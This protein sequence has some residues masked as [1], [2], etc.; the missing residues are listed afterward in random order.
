[1]DR[2]LTEGAQAIGRAEEEVSCRQG[3]NDVTLAVNLPGAVQ[4]TPENPALQIATMT[5]EG[6]DGT[7]TVQTY[8]GMRK[9]GRG[10]YA[11]SSHEFILLNGKPVYLRGA[12]H[13]SFNPEGVYTHPDD[14]FIRRDYEKAKE[15]GLNFLRIHIK[16]DEP[17]ALYWADRLG[18]MLMCDMPNF[19]RK[20]DRSKRLWQQ[21]MY[22]AVARDFNH[23]AI[24]AW[25]NFNET[26]GIGDNGYD[27]ETQNWVRDMYLET[28]R[29]DPT[30][31]VE[32]NS[33]C[34]YDHTVSDINSWHFYID[35]Y[36]VARRHIEEVTQKHYPGSAFNYAQG[37]KQNTAPLI[38]S[39]Y[40]GVGAGSGDRDISW[41]F[42]HLT[43][44]LRS[45]ETIGGYVYT[46]LSDIEWEHNGFMNYDRSDKVYGYPA[47]I[48]LKDLQGEE[49]VV[50]RCAPYRRVEAGGRA[51]V[52]ISL[53]HW[54]EREGLRLRLSAHGETIAGE[55]WDRYVAPQM[56]D[57]RAVPYHVTPQGEFTVELPQESGIL[58]LA[59]EA[60]DGDKRVA[61]NYCV[62]DVRGVPLDHAVDQYAIS[63]P[64]SAFSDCSFANQGA[65]LHEQRDKVYGF[66]SGQIAY[67]LKLPDDLRGDNIEGC[68]LILELGA[69]ADDELLDWPARRN[70]M[71]YPQTD[72]RTHPTA[73]QIAVNGNAAAKI[74]IGSDYADARGVLSHAAGFHHGSHGAVF[75][76]DLAEANA[77]AGLQALLA[78]LAADR[79]VILTLTALEDAAGGLALYGKEMGQFPLDPTLLFKLKP[80]APKPKGKAGA[81]D[82]TLSSE[83]EL[84]KT[85]P[86]GDLWRFTFE[87]PAEEWARPGFDDAAWRKGK[88]GFGTPETPGARIGTRWDTPD[89]WLRTNVDLPSE[90]GAEPVRLV[91]HHD[92]DVKVY[93]NGDLLVEQ[94][95][96]LQDYEYHTLTPD[97]IALF[98]PGGQNL[99]AVHCRQTT[100][101]QFIDVGLITIE[102]KKSRS[103]E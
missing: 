34:S 53:S 22:E 20:T 81:V 50:L 15:F 26:W 32:D 91:L 79:R 74:D 86:E 68:T 76:I 65:P 47:D 8:F 43:N 17:R 2:P 66:K 33:P 72:G 94:R 6:P 49:F 19:Q 101:G 5:L 35:D 99:V 88:A 39:E 80:G 84:L 59:V 57:I 55:P 63:W 54:S 9:V 93:V 64:V 38:N 40:G 11:G 44:L 46:E 98:R 12:L 58:H 51:A 13:Q 70:P 95:G 77:G 24:I 1:V 87:R 16:I 97:Q 96:F 41:C 10:K 71:D 14:A 18:V 7:D 21:T 52:P 100:G 4:W 90:F 73:V 37:W 62:L 103:S 85:G 28:K 23:P 69:R 82:T 27:K 36:E 56:R 48:A 83:H 61:A 31:L 25:C 67:T 78:A 75:R 42:L 45:H 30:R 89:I 92:E 3:L 60:L 29:I 102:T